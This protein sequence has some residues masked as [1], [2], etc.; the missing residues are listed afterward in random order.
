MSQEVKGRTNKYS[1]E[2]RVLH[3]L[4]LKLIKAY[5]VCEIQIKER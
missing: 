3:Y 1:T 5:F 2:L 4:V